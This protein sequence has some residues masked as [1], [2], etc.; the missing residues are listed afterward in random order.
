MPWVWP[1]K[2]RRGSFHR[3]AVETNPTRTHEVV[4]LIP[5]LAQWVK[6]PALPWAMV[7][8]R[9]GS[10]P[11]LLWLWCR[12]VAIA[13]IRPLAWELPNAV[14]AA[15]KRQKNTIERERQTL[16]DITRMWNLKHGTN[17]PIYKQK[18]TH[19]HR[20]QTCGLPRGRR[21]GEGKSGNLGLADA[22]YCNSWTG[23]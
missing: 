4:G 1:L 10:D 17:D 19:R 7:W 20:E 14:G 16:Y 22:N 9:R 21:V 23:W 11:V 6:D 12:P 13:P 2:K 8:V 18:Q 15:L 3:S 5:G